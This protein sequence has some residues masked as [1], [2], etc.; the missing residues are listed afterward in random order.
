MS[1]VDGSRRIAAV[2][3]GVGAG[4]SIRNSKR[5][6]LSAEANAAGSKFRDPFGLPGTF[7][8]PLAMKRAWRQF[9]IYLAE[10]SAVEAERAAYDGMSRIVFKFPIRWFNLTPLLKAYLNEV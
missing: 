1:S 10:R 4:C 3:A 6:A 8:P 2:I 7:L 9:F 5:L